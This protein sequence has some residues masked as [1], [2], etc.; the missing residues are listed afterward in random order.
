MYTHIHLIPSP[1]NITI[2]CDYL[3]DLDAE[4]VVVW[5]A[6]LVK[7]ETK[8]LLPVNRDAVEVLVCQCQPNLQRD[9][10]SY[11]Q[12]LRFLFPPALV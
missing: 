9:D 4:G 11:E 12:V 5:V 7:G 2:R 1:P 3:D 8:R 6:A 10:S